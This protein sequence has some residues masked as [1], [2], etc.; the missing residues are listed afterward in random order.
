[1][2]S[3]NPREFYE[4]QPDKYRIL[5]SGAVMELATGKLCDNL[6]GRYTLTPEKGLELQRQHY[7][8]TQAAIGEAVLSEIQSFADIPINTPRDAYAYIV[9][10]QAVA[11]MDYDKPRMEDTQL[12]GQLM[13]EVPR[14]SELRDATAAA[15]AAGAFALVA[16]IERLIEERRAN[17]IEGKVNDG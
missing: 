14:L 17:V 4:S 15:T 5:E 16:L 7:Q 10:K 6:G 13:G 3:K 9:K 2:A 1:M 12:L 8:Q 11:L